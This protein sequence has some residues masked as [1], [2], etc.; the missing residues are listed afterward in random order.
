MTARCALIIPVGPDDH[1]YGELL[2]SLHTLQSEAGARF[3][4]HLACCKTSDVERVNAWLKHHQVDA[5]VHLSATG[6][7][8]QQNHAAA[9]TDADWLWFVHADSRIDA[10]VVHQLKWAMQQAQPDA[11]FYFKLGF[12]EPD[13]RMR[14]NEFGVWLRCQLFALPFGDQAFF[15]QRSTFDKLGKFPQQ[16]AKGEDHALIWRAKALK[17]RIKQLPA[18]LRTSARRYQTAGWLSTTVAHLGMTW[19]QAKAMRAWAKSV[20]R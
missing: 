20:E 18:T 15:M 11:I 3:E 8:L 10:A 16:F 17:M 2:L 6:R 4:V 12:S 19:R 5:N 7:A 13:W 9:S 1:A 14:I